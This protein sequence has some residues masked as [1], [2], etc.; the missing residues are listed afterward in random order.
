VHT[1]L[2]GV[3]AN[4]NLHELDEGIQTLYGDENRQLKAIG[5]ME[6]E[7]AEK[8]ISVFNFVD[9]SNVDSTVSAATFIEILINNLGAFPSNVT[10]RL[11]HTYLV[12]KKGGFLTRLAIRL[13]RS[14]SV[15]PDLQGL[16]N[17]VNK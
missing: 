1:V 2:K 11:E 17:E 12:G 3:E 8:V 5:V 16:V 4:P 9:I 15:V 7:P 6:V 14:T 10:K 13:S